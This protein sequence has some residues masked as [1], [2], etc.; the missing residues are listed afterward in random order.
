MAFK[1][2]G[3]PLRS[4]FKHADKGGEHSEEDHTHID[5]GEGDGS[6]TDKS[7]VIMNPEQQEKYDIIKEKREKEQIALSH[8]TYVRNKEIYDKRLADGKITQAEYNEL[9]EG[10]AAMKNPDALDQ[11]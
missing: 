3:F 6:I 7:S 10:I 11:D 4:G 8:K 2:K 1:M 5:A 9:M